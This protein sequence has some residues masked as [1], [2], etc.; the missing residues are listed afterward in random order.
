MDNLSAN[1][2]RALARVFNLL[3]SERDFKL[4]LSPSNLQAV[5]AEPE[6]F[7]ISS[8]PCLHFEGPGNAR[9]KEHVLSRLLTSITTKVETLEFGKTESM[10]VGDD[11]PIP[12]PPC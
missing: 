4:L 5:F 9:A 6:D 10:A 12:S 3:R 1:Q 11:F 8:V 2:F 7:V